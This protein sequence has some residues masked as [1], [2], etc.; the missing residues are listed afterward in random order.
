[1]PGRAEAEGIRTSD[2][3]RARDLKGPANV[4]KSRSH[5]GR[6]NRRRSRGLPGG[7]EP[8][9]S[10]VQTPARLTGSSLLFLGVSSATQAPRTSCRSLRE[11]RVRLWRPHIG[12]GSHGPIRQQYRRSVRPVVRSSPGP[13]CERTSAAVF[14]RLRP[15]HVHAPSRVGGAKLQRE[16][17]VALND[18]G[19]ASDAKLRFAWSLFQKSAPGWSRVQTICDFVHRHIEFGYEHARPTMTS[20]EVFNEGKGVCRDYAHLAITFCRCM[21]IPARYCTGYLG[22]IGV[23]PPYGPPPQA[24][25]MS[26]CSADQEITSICADFLVELRGCSI[27][28]EDL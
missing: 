24:A 21:N 20:W 26:R 6:G 13:G 3:C 27:G 1:M 4:R 10:A 23:P 16:P 12:A 14:F 2:L 11:P 5:L 7:F 18:D 25:E 8:L 28:D 22:E 15:I 17:P 9:T 19:S